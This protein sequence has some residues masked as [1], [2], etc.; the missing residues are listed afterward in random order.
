MT[1]SSIPLPISEE[2]SRGK[3][4]TPAVWS[5]S[6]HSQEKFSPLVCRQL[7]WHDRS[8]KLDEF[9]RRGEYRP[10]SRRLVVRCRRQFRSVRRQRHGV[11]R[12][13]VT[14][15]YRHFGTGGDIPNGGSLVPG[16][17]DHALPTV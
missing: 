17:G 10:N 11:N 1:L 14:V 7:S 12:I 4:A 15:K 5:R 6:V 9:L 8:R 3:S 16:C 2:V 13:V